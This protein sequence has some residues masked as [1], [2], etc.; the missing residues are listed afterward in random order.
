MAMNNLGS[1]VLSDLNPDGIVF[2]NADNN[3]EYINSAFSDITGFSP[4]DLIGLNGDVFNAQMQALCDDDACDVFDINKIDGFSVIQLYEQPRRIISC[5]L[6]EVDDKPSKFLGRALYFHDITRDRERDERIK[7]EFLSVSAHKLRTPLVGILGF[8]ELLLK[9]EF[10]PVK[11]NDVLATI[12]RQAT[13]LKQMLDDFLDIERL[14]VRKGG[15]FHF[16]KGTLEAVLGEVLVTAGRSSAPVEIVFEPPDV[17]PEVNFDFE[18]MK[19]VFTNLIS[20]AVKYS[21]EGGQV[22]CGTAV[23]SNNGTNEF[24][25]TISDQGIGI[26]SDDLDRVGERFYRTDISQSV[27]GS[28]LGIAIVKSIV[29]IH[30]GHFELSSEKGKGT[31]AAVWLSML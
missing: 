20:N 31:T 5:T 11:Q 10:D 13:Y 7:S 27:S 3:I 1:N 21:T 29:A 12:F 14:D 9:R 6:R 28:G 24:G 23:R 26:A 17:W 18:K 8:S 19:Q 25:V 4:N 2:I 16:K 22:V 15:D 30:K